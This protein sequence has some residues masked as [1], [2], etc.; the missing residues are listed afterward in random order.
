MGSAG[1]TSSTRPRL[2]R[3]LGVAPWVVAG[4]GVCASLVLPGEPSGPAVRGALLVTLALF[5][6]LLIARLVLA[7]TT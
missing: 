2:L 4:L 7:V 1:G 3:R 6:A 5:F